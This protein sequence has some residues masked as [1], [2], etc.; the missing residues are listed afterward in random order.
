M[1]YVCPSCGRQLISRLGPN[2]VFCGVKVPAHLLFSKEERAR[3][4]AQE[5]VQ[6]ELAAKEAAQRKKRAESDSAQYIPPI[7]FDS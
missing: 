7:S 6:E 3:I 1:R 2:C 4:D 5:R